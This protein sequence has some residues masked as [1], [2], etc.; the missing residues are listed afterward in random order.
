MSKYGKSRWRNKQSKAYIIHIYMYLWYD[1]LILEAVWG[2]I[3]HVGYQQIIATNKM[4]NFTRSCF[5]NAFSS[6]S[7]HQHEQKW[8]KIALI[9]LYSMI[10]KQRNLFL[11]VFSTHFLKNSNFGFVTIKINQ[12]WMTHPN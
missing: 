2:Y 11:F 3:P 5:Q 10:H 12:F 9:L 4:V 8:S 6:A 7:I 1:V